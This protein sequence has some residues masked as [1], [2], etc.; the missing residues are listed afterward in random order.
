MPFTKLL[1]AALMLAAVGCTDDAST[2]SE[3]LVV[4]GK[5]VDGRSVLEVQKVEGDVSTRLLIDLKTMSIAGGERIVK[6]T[7]SPGL[8]C[9]TVFP[10]AQLTSRDVADL[11][12]ALAS[13]VLVTSTEDSCNVAPANSISEPTLIDGTFGVTIGGDLN[14]KIG[15]FTWT[16]TDTDGG[17]VSFKD[18]TIKGMFVQT[19]DVLNHTTFATTVGASMA[20]TLTAN[21]VAAADVGALVTASLNS[22]VTSGVYDNASDVVQFAFPQANLDTRL[23]P[24]IKIGSMALVMAATA[25][26]VSS[27]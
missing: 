14:I 11:G 10:T 12:Q 20:K 25:M 16:D 1:P 13:S 3:P 5:A 22:L 23:T 26:S 27:S 7:A 19:I 6:L 21:G 9:V 2:V 8:G 18:I 15:A 24:T 4:N 17:S